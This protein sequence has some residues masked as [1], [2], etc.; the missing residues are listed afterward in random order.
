MPKS[1]LQSNWYYGIIKDYPSD[2]Y[3]GRAVRAYE[4]LEKLGY[5]QVP[6]SSTWN[7]NFNTYQTVAL[8]KDKISP[9]RLKGFMTIPWTATERKNIYTLKN[10]AERLYLA[11]KDLYPE[12]L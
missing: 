5:D 1:V 4:A 3:G 11:R 10:D 7:N 8:G 9:D 2:S 6:S 12:T